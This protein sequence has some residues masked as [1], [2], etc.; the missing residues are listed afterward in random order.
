MSS[1][2]GSLLKISVFGQSHGRAIGVN[3]DGLPAGEAIDFE[4]LN[5]FLDRR[6]P[7]KDG[8]STPR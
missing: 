7:G 8:L 1:E 6:R 5:A 2:F 4:E 3:M